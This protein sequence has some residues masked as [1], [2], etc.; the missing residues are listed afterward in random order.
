MH[1]FEPRYKEMIGECLAQHRH[2]GV[3]R[4][5]EQGLAEV[6]CTAEIVT[7]VKEYPDGRLD[8]VAE[9][10][11]RFELVRVNQER[12]FLQAEVLMIADEPGTPPPA[13]TSRAV[14]LH[15]ELMAIAGAKQDLSAADPSLLSFYLAGSLPLDLDFKQKLLSLRSEPER[16]SLFI[17]YL[18]TIIPNLRRTAN[19]REKAGGNGHVH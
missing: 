15:S 6:G 10:R 1:I 17:S 18:E 12:P 19:A 3:V 4:A 8:L 2:F 13:D 11:N 16:L 9:G 5:V 14:Q 7:V